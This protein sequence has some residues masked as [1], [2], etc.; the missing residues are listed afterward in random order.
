MGLKEIGCE[1]VDWIFVAEGTYTYFKWS[2]SHWKNSGEWKN[3]I[4]ISIFKR[5]NYK[6]KKII[7]KKQRNV[8]YKYI[9]NMKQI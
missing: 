4:V 7:K 9:K 5:G 1:G 8:C 3:A 6:Y 2:V